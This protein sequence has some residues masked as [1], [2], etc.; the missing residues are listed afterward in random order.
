MLE[1]PINEEGEG[2]EKGDE[3]DGV[4]LLGIDVCCIVGDPNYDVISNPDY[5]M[6]FNI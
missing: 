5:Y 6:E 3:N 1:N 2:A 4:Q